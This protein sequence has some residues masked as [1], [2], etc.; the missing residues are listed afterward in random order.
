MFCI[1]DPN[2]VYYDIFP[3]H[4]NIAV[5]YMNIYGSIPIIILLVIL[6]NSQKRRYSRKNSFT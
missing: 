3:L 2:K 6:Y 5:Y 4:S 1:L